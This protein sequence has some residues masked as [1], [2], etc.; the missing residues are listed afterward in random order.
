VREPKKGGGGQE[1]ET[2]WECVNMGKTWVDRSVVGAKV[3]RR[4]KK[5]VGG[6]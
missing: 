6:G 5:E 2:R 4:E 3:V 1:L